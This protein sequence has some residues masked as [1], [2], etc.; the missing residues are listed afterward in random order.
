MPS[1]LREQKATRQHAAST[2][3]IVELDAGAK[4]RAEE[5]TSVHA[6]PDYFDPKRGIASAA[7]GATGAP[8]K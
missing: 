1:A 7:A 6:A 5:E 8:C 2:Q 4:G 3:G